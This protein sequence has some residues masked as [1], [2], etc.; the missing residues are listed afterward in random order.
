[1]KQSDTIA[2][3]AT[4]LSEFQKEVGNVTKD[5][6]NPFFKSRYASLENVI[7]T[8][9]PIL[10]KHGLSYSQFP[11]EE[12]L[13]TIL[14]HSSGEYLTASSKLLMKDATPQGQGSAITY[15]R[16]YALSAVLGIATEDDD[17]GEAGTK[18]SR[19]VVKTKPSP[20]EEKRAKI[21]TLCD[22][23]CLA[24]LLSKEEYHTYIKDNTGLDMASENFDAIIKKL[25]ELK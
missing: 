21:K 15:L 3:I 25:T 14:M 12:G 13:T 4:A 24:P 8:V 10:A 19:T 6:T 9:K 22:D 16:R 23:R 18:P 1:M 17:D 5:A 20:D 7:S 2:V 11:D